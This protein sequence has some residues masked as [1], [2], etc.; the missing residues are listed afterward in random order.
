MAPSWQREYIRPI[1][2]EQALERL[3]RNP[4]N[5]ELIP[6][7]S[8]RFVLT[9]VAQYPWASIAI[10]MVTPVKSKPRISGQT[11]A[12]PDEALQHAAMGTPESVHN[13]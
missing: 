1:G 13:R 5:A 12:S 10:R 8:C 6:L 11:G 4:G 7:L 9:H 2:Y 3:L